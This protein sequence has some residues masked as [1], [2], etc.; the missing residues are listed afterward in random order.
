MGYNYHSAFQETTYS[1]DC[2][3]QIALA[4]VL[5]FKAEFPDELRVEFKVWQK[6]KNVEVVGKQTVFYTWKELGF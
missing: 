2:L 5:A 3:K 6:S 4:A 1:T